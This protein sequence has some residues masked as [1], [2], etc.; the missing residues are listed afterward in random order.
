MTSH[1]FFIAVMTTIWSLS[2]ENH[3]IQH[4]CKAEH[5]RVTF[6]LSAMPPY[7]SM[8][9]DN[10]TKMVL[11]CNQKTND[12]FFNCLT[13]ENTTFF[14]GCV[15]CTNNWKALIMY[16]A[17]QSDS[18]LYYFFYLGLLLALDLNLVPTRLM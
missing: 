10:C 12:M 8:S 7:D 15:T 17:L 9:R 6:E 5:H 18:N 3:S 13:S 4:C 1:P 16:Y 11:L 2:L 14:I